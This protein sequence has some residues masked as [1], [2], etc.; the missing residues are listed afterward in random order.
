MEWLSEEITDRLIWAV[1]DMDWV[2]FVKVS[3]FQVS[4]ICQGCPSMNINRA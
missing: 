4:F 3:Y 2:G 1:H